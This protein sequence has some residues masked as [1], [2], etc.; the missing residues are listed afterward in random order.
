MCSHTAMR[1]FTPQRLCHLLS[2]VV[3]VR[4]PISKTY[5][6]PYREK[7]PEIGINNRR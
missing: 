4:L 1:L 2:L 3:F 6:I 5:N 7:V